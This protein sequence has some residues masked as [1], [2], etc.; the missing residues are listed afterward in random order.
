ME[1]VRKRR[2]T[3]Q[4]RKRQA[5]ARRAMAWV[6]LFLAMSAVFCMAT[7]QSFAACAW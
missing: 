2:R 3:R 1:S 7:V 5:E 4:E 6:I